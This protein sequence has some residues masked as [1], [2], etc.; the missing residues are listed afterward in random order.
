M[1]KC[2]EMLYTVRKTGKKINGVINPTMAGGGGGGGGEGA[3]VFVLNGEI[4]Y[5]KQNFNCMHILG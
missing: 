4:F 1:K 2:T 5:S 3:S